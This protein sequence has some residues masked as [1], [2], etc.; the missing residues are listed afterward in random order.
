MV[1]DFH[2]R[3][4]E[5]ISA[6]WSVA[7][8][9][10]AVSADF[11]AS[12]HGKACQEE[13]G[14]ATARTP[15]NPRVPAPGPPPA[16][17]LS[18]TGPRQKARRAPVDLSDPADIRFRTLARCL[19]A[20]N[21]GDIDSIMS[22]LLFCVR[23]LFDLIVTLLLWTCYLSLFFLI[24]FPIY[25]GAFFFASER[26]PAFQRINCSFY[27]G[28][29]A[30]LR[31]LAPRLRVSVQ[32]DISSIRSSVIVCNHLSY[33]DPILM[34]SLL[35]RQKTI[36]KGVFFRVPFVS[37]VVRIS[38]Y[39]PATGEPALVPLMME[40]IEGMEGYLAS[41]GNLFVFPEGTRSR[42]GRLGSFSKGAFSIARRCRAPI[43][44]LRIQNTGALWSPGRFL[45]NAT[46]K[47]EIRVRRI[48]TL[49]PD[50][51]S[52]SFSLQHLME[53]VRS[54]YQEPEATLR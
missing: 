50:Y 11:I 21:P 43:H 48:G 52:G 5:V 36:V 28:F 31:I 19:T 39:I 1:T 23:R 33:L 37:W 9:T 32:D 24:F 3:R 8:A 38:G 26:E 34:I 12:K 29:F 10:R 49:L 2:P 13:P 46:E 42:D 22:A 18:R 27:R 15:G 54:R 30:L 35:R 40:R 6:V 51:E 7:G 16:Q 25:A 41:G 47:I 44:I 45:F 20:Q 4:V 14:K 53:E 17:T